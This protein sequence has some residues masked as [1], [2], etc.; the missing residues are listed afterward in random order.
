MAWPRPKPQA[1]ILGGSPGI[2]VETW[3]H[4]RDWLRGKGPYKDEVLLLRLL[5]L[6]PFFCIFILSLS[7]TNRL[8]STL[9]S[10]RAP[11][12]TPPATES[13][14]AV[15]EYPSDRNICMVSHI[16]TYTR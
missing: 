9:S 6:L 8:S 12:A 7:R 13:S 4:A 16:S 10:Q 3:A 5:F 11:F 15:C 2:P 1:G 14:T